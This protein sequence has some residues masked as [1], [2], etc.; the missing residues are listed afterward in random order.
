MSL[1]GK[2]GSAEHFHEGN[3]TKIVQTCKRSRSTMFVES[4]DL[5]TSSMRG[6]PI[7]N[8]NQARVH[9]NMAFIY[10]QHLLC[11]NFSCSDNFLKIYPSQS[12]SSI[13]PSYPPGLSFLQ[14]SALGLDRVV[15]DATSPSGEV[16]GN[17][18]VLRYAPL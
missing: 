12:Q 3:Y 17:Q 4:C 11:W 14:G 8:I 10:K 9:D 2:K 1:S 18:G 15:D 6:G 7:Q 5:D 16:H 13:P